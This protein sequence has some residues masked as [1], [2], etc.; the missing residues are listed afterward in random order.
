MA[1]NKALS[2][3]KIDREFLSHDDKRF[4]ELLN[5][6]F[7]RQMETARMNAEAKQTLETSI[8]RG[9]LNR[10]NKAVYT[11][12]RKRRVLLPKE[13]SLFNALL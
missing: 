12:T 5:R 11:A 6:E 4:D 13:T 1:K 3:R 9:T 8:S 7:E 10:N 2:R